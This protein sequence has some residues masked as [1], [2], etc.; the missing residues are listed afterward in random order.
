MASHEAPIKYSLHA[1]P[2]VLEVGSA[3]VGHG[4]VAGAHIDVDTGLLPPRPLDLGQLLTRDAKC[5]V[6]NPALVTIL[7][8]LLISKIESS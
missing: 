8:F 7:L 2:S 4:Q 3:P 6:H 5:L 1:P